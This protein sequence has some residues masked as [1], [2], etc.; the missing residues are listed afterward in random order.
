MALCTFPVSAT[1]TSDTWIK[2]QY[3]FYVN[4]ICEDY[5]I[6]PELVIAII[7]H[8]SS[9]RADVSNVNCKGLMQIY[10]KY[11]K[12]R[13][14]RLG[15]TDLYDP[16]SNILVGVDYLAE[17]FGEYGDLPMVLMVYNGSSDA[18]KRWENGNY[19]DY[20]NSIMERT[21]DLENIKEEENYNEQ[22]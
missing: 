1:E 20:A 13:M 10:E 21:R 2:E 17:L 9:G 16:Y 19:T 7:E 5:Y 11:H 22:Y 4:E 3:V 8:E 12:D 6:C 14:E 18:E 15:V